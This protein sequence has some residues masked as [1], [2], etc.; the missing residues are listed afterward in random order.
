MLFEREVYSI[1]YCCLDFVDQQVLL[2]VNKVGTFH[3]NSDMSG[4]VG[5]SHLFLIC[6]SVS[7]TPQK[8]KHK[9]K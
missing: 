9:N 7:H 4:S 2:R 1:C 8:Q 5:T 6:P 3:P